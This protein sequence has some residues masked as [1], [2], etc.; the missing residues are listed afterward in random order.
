M[1]IS[2]FREHLKPVEEFGPGGE[3]QQQNLRVTSAAS[4][5]A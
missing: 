5:T 4:M 3:G 1:E 2:G